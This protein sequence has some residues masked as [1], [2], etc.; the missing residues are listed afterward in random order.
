[1]SGTVTGI[2]TLSD[3]FGTGQASSAQPQ[4]EEHLSQICLCL[5]LVS[6]MLQRADRTRTKARGWVGG[7]C[8]RGF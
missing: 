2:T 5:E 6:K 3:S 8:F 7:S 1:M 4:D